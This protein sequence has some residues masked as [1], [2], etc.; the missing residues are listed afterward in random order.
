MRF[1][2]LVLAIFFAPLV[3]AA[4]PAQVVV[5]PMAPLITV[6]ALDPSATEGG[7]SGVFAFLRQNSTNQDVRV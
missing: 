4:L 6:R 5:D 2:R 3:I 1:V 7:D